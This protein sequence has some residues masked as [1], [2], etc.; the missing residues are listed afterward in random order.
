LPIAHVDD[1]FLFGNIAG[2]ATLY[3]G[4]FDSQ[5]VLTFAGMELPTGSKKIGGGGINLQ[6][7]QARVKDYDD[8]RGYISYGYR[9]TSKVDDLDTGDTLNFVIGMDTPLEKDLPIIGRNY[10]VYGIAITQNVGSTKYADFDLKDG[11]TTLDLSGGLIWR[12]KNIRFGLTLPI[13]TISDE[14]DNS[15]RIMS[16]D[17]GY[18]FGGG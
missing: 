7:G 1:E 16:L 14:I 10:S 4:D 13:I 6:V 8:T 2:T 11:R 9:Y 5:L 3:S 17:I 12:A 18:R 15:D